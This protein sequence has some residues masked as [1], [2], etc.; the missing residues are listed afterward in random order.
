MVR[1]REPVVV[2]EPAAVQEPE[3]AHQ[4]VVAIPVKEPEIV[5]SAKVLEMVL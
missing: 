5:L 2:Q 3:A 4:N 1:H